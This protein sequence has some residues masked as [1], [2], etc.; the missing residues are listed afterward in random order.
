MGIAS[1][2]RCTRPASGAN[3]YFCAWVEVMVVTQTGDAPG[4]RREGDVIEASY[5]LPFPAHAEADA[6]HGRLRWMS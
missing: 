6:L 1:G 2:H 3:G 4:Q 5:E